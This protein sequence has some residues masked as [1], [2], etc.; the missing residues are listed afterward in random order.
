MEVFKLRNGVKPTYAQRKII[1]SRGLDTYEYLVVKSVG[2]TGLLLQS[3]HDA[4]KT[5]VVYSDRSGV[6]DKKG[7]VLIS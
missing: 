7:E 6:Y 3:K 5:C 4:S 2:P 1:E